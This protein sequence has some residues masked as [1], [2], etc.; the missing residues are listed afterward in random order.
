MIQHSKKNFKKFKGIL[1][2]LVYIFIPLLI[3]II[4]FWGYFVFLIVNIKSFESLQFS[5]TIILRVHR[6]NSL[7]FIENT[8]PAF[9]DAL[10][11]DKYE[12]IEMK[13]LD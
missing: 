10:K 4:V 2:K 11:K 9:E 6:G 12:F 8:I 13:L 7:D 3:I 5:G 1:N